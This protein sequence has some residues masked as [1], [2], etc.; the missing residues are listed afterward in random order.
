MYSVLKHLILILMLC[1]VVIVSAKHSKRL[2]VGVNVQF[3]PYEY[4]DDEKHVVGSNIDILDD[5]SK[6]S[7]FHFKLVWGES[8]VI[9]SKFEK[10][11]LQML[12]GFCKTPQLEKKYLFTVP[13]SYI[14]YAVFIRNDSETVTNWNDLSRKQVLIEYG[15]VVEEFLTEKG[16][17]AK[18]LYTSSFR[19]ALE[20]LSYGIGDAVVIPKIQGYMYIAQFRWDNLTDVNSPSVTLPY[21]FVLPLGYEDT[22]NK[23]NQSLFKLEETGQMRNSQNKWLGVYKRETTTLERHTGFYRGLLIVIVFGLLTIGIFIVSLV[24]RIRQQKNYLAL[25]LAERNNYEKEFNQRH[26]LFVTGPIIFLKWNDSKREMFDSISDNFAVFG[27][28]P[29]DIMS[30][31]IPFRNIIHP[32]DLEWILFQRQQHLDRREFIYYQ[33]YRIVCPLIGDVDTS[34]DVVNTWHERNI[35]LN[36]LNTVQIRWVFDYT[37]VLPDEVSNSYHFYGYLLDITKQKAFESAL[38]QK[39]SDAQVAINIKDIFLTSISVEINSPLNALIGLARKVSDKDLTEEQS[40]SLHTIS[41][42]ALH[43]KQILQQIHDFLNILKGS[44]GSV[45]QW[46]VL[47]SLIEPIITEFQIKIASKQLAF[48]YN[49]FQPS[50]LVF[51]DSDWFQ[52]IIRIVLDNAVKFTQEGKIELMVDLVRKSPDK[53]ELLVKIAD[54]GVGIP[55]DKLNLIME[56]FTQVDET[57][58]RRFGGIGLGLS[59]ARNLL[60]Q[61]NGLIQID[62]KPNQGTSIELRFPVDT[63]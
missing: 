36:N 44:M 50:A 15:S 46:Y 52:K 4:L 16:I 58:T 42:S 56:P 25:Q 48:E 24:K 3:P 43:L 51:L 30:G 49:E 21:C 62:S 40:S 6:D 11:E 27:Y 19:D 35:A 17:A 28:D 54:T 59:I 33:I 31:K 1:S 23:I 47:K 18:Y 29:T 9:R 20:K 41:D 45:P 39:H 53:A 63:K 12:S 2:S 10:G 34:N 61:M 26:K 5:V 60:I 57:Y 38:F 22:R 7:G 8:N 55:K 13:F 32:D 14:T 37:V